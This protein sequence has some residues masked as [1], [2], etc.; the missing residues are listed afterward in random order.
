[1]RQETLLTGPPDARLFASL[2]ITTLDGI[3]SQ[4]VGCTNLEAS[5]NN[6]LW[7]FNLIVY[8]FSPRSHDSKPRSPS[9]GCHHIALSELSSKKASVV[10]IRPS[11]ALRV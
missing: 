6:T 1:M 3:L 8:L 7:H 9:C 10:I 11:T 4:I 5:V 2:M